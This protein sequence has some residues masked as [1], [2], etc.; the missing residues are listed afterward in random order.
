MVIAKKI[1]NFID[2]NAIFFAFGLAFLSLATW[3]FNNALS[4]GT[5][6]GIIY[7][8]IVLFFIVLLAVILIVDNS[9]NYLAITIVSSIY[10]ITNTLVVFLIKWTNGDDSIS[11]LTRF[12]G[13]AQIIGLIAIVYILYILMK[14]TFMRIQVHAVLA[15]V[16][17]LALTAVLYSICFQF[18]TIVNSFTAE[19]ATNYQVTSF[20]PDK[21]T[22]G[23][24]LLLGIICSFFLAE[25]S[26]LN[27][28]YFFIIPLALFLVVSRAKICLLLFLVFG[29]ALGIYKLIINWKK[30]TR[31][32][33]IVISISAVVVTLFVLFLT[34]DAFHQ[35][36][37]FYQAYYYIT[38]TLI[39]DGI[40]TLTKRIEKW[41]NIASLLNTPLVFVGYGERTSL[42]VLQ[43]IGYKSSDN[44]YIS[45]L[46]EG[47]I[48]K[49][50]CYVL[51]LFLVI[52]YSLRKMNNLKYNV[53]FLS[54]L[55]LILILGIFEDVPLLSSS[56]IPLMFSLVLVTIP[57]ATKVYESTTVI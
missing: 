33:V 32:A 36:G 14:K 9:D 50:A 8:L 19:H 16:I 12:G 41:Q 5:I 6:P 4:N 10:L 17:G 47:G 7:R 51:F 56:A 29:L 39:N 22:F 28:Y 18:S 57:N 53:F 24:V 30:H 46:L 40:T 25:L 37:I 26:H 43:S 20:F 42:F 54:A 21:N 13:L 38:H 15:L 35:D 45:F 31:T 27:R 49:I 11:M 44:V 3:I 48:T 1:L 34:V 52:N 23:Y 55:S 2:R